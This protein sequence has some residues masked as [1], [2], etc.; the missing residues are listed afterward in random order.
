[1]VKVGAQMVVVRVV[2]DEEGK[3][4]QVGGLQGVG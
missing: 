1:V 2:A 3:E 4:L